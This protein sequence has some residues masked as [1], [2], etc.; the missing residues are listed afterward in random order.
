[1]TRKRKNAGAGYGFMFHGAFNEKRDAVAKEKKTP[2]AFIKMVPA[3]DGGGFRYA[4]M[5]PRK[6]PLKRRRVKGEPFDGHRQPNFFGLFASRESKMSP[7]QLAK[8]VFPVRG[9]YDGKHISG[10]RIWV[11]ITGH[12]GRK[13]TGVLDNEPKFIRGKHLGSSVSFRRAQIVEVMN[14]SQPNPT[15]LLVM[16]A[17]PHAVTNPA[18][19]GRMIGGNPCSRKPGHKGPCLPQGATMRTAARLPKSWRGPQV[20]SNPSA[21]ALREEFT[22]TP[23]EFVTIE[24]EPHIP[25]GD[26]AALGELLSLYVKPVSGG[27]VQEISFGRGS[28][29]PQLLSDETARQLYFAGGDQNLTESLDAFGAVSHGGNVYELG[30][31]KRIDYK[32]RKEHVG[33]P[34]LDEWR[35]NFGE[36]SG[37]RPKLL[38]DGNN[39]RLLLAGGE[40]VVRRE[41][42]VN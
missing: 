37:V 23:A 6:N 13:Y 20:R 29:R 21:A 8:V 27:Q 15:E 40:Y 41:G 24:H 38:F 3:P 26:Y 14:P 36:E 35:H 31:V 2:G 12:R 42:I 33:H 22:G 34:D 25:K 19:C 11:R 10:E 39:K 5:S 9:S 30:E 28:H 1:M 7:G 32:Q 4:V 18:T 17:N 16:G